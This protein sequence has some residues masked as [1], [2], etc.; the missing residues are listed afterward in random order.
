LG[1]P[2]PNPFNPSTS[3]NWELPMVS[4]Y[5]LEIY[6]LAGHLV[7]TLESGSAPAGKYH[8]I[9]QAQGVASGIYFVR[10]STPSFTQTRKVMFL[11]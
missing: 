3:I 9:W 10:L 2:Y 11:K 5:T 6:D 4:K 8:T 7:Q 1:E